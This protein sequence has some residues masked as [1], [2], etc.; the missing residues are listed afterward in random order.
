MKITNLIKKD[1]IIL[2]LESVKKED[3]LEELIEELYTA[4]RLNDREEFKKEILKRESEG[5]TGIGDGI[6]IPHAKTKAVKIPSIA[7]GRSKTG[8]DFDSLD[9]EPTNLFFMIAASEGADN[10]HLETLSKLATF[11]M[12][13]D[14]SKNLLKANS[15]EE[16]I[17]IIDKKEMEEENKLAK[18]DTS[19]DVKREKI[20]AVTACP[21]G[22]AHTYMAAD[23]LKQK[24]EEMG[25]DIK[26]ETNGSTG[27]KNE[28]TQED[29]R[30]AKAIIV[31]ADTKVYMDRFDGKKVI[32]TPVSEAIKNPQGLI[33]RALEGEGNIYKGKGETSS[34][35]KTGGKNIYTNLM[36][37]VS[38]MLPFVVGGGILIALS[39]LFDFNNAGG[40]DYGSGNSIAAFF[41][42][43][44]GTAFSFM[45]PILAGYIA[46]S[47]GDRPALAPGF[48]GGA[49]A[50][51]GNAGFLGALFAGFLAGYIVV[52]LR[53]LFDKLPNSLEGIKPVLLFPLFGILIVGFVMNFIIVPP[54]EALNTGMNNFLNTLGGSNKVILGLLL[55]GM[56]AVDMGGPVNKAAYVFGVA[57]V[58][59]GNGH[60]M[61]AVMAGGMVP[62]L[63][64]ALAT[65]LFKDKFTLAERDAGKTNYVMGLS[66]ITE[67]AIPFA[68]A[69][70]KSVIP[71]I[72]V[73][74]AI[75]GGLSE[76]FGASSPAPHGGIFVF[77]V[78]SNWLLYFASI[79]IG[80]VVTAILL[81]ILKKDIQIQKVNS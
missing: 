2:N 7:F 47:I 32:Q 77:P 79:L 33:K 22:I 21:T 41:N 63:G 13:K 35:S 60:I 68:A 45:L 64:I 46:F 54:V 78:V 71:S 28:L 62:P 11:L 25:V 73:G 1:T 39:F 75:A 61:A 5:T 20:L 40:G 42:T 49:L 44:G 38:N 19:Q 23:A 8:V 80:S 57:S 36:N 50:A 72:I 3:I 53:K 31:S 10:D 37:G 66:F 15:K 18:K 55:G 59:E 34:T 12:D 48:V 51:N 26:V 81:K 27:V 74:S 52:G 30:E 4:N 76:L 6:A 67:G 65:T 29:I 69:D 24:A 14:F 58:A 9:G 43:L 17:E 16:I 70:P 56:M